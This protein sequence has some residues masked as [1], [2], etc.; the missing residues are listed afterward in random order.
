MKLLL[1]Q[2]KPLQTLILADLASGAPV[3]VDKTND[4][5]DLAPDTPPWADQA[6]AW[7]NDAPEACAWADEAPVCAGKTHV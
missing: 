4:S 1:G 6:H 2:I 5:A 3:W 7:A